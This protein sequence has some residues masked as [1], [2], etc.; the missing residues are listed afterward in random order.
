LQEGADADAEARHLQGAD[1]VVQQ[2]QVA[3]QA[4]PSAGD[5]HLP[6]VLKKL[7]KWGCYASFGECVQPTRFVPCKVSLAPSNTS[8][9]SQSGKAVLPKLTAYQLMQTP[10]SEQIL[11]NWSLPEEPVHRL[12]VGTLL[13]EQRARGRSLGMILDLSNHE[14][15]VMLCGGWC[16]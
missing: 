15:W 9:Q 1:V 5:Q 16:P 6:T 7:H 2:Q 11:A 10:L 12:T 3:T 4:G 14:W 13:D 8:K